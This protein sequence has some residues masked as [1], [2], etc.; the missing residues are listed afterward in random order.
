MAKGYWIAHVTVSDPDQYKQYADTAPEAF[1]KY[2][3][4]IL[5]GAGQHTQLEGNGK[6]RNVVIEFDSYQA[7]VDCYNSDEYQAARAKRLGAGEAD[8]V[9]VEGV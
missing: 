5:A 3:G 1:K 7:A 8:I 9:I 2:N 4:R 6:A